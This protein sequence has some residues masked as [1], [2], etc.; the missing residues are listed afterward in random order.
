MATFVSIFT[1]RD[2]QWLKVP[3]I[4]ALDGFGDWFI[5]SDA[6]A[7]P[8]EEASSATSTS[9]SSPSSSAFSSQFSLSSSTLVTLCRTR[10][11]S[12][13]SLLWKT[14]SDLQA[15]LLK[16]KISAISRLAQFEGRDLRCGSEYEQC[17]QTVHK[18]TLEE[19]AVTRSIVT[20]T[21][22][23]KWTTKETIQCKMGWN[24]INGCRYYLCRVPISRHFPSSSSPSASSGVLTQPAPSNRLEIIRGQSTR[25]SSSFSSS[26]TSLLSTASQ[27]PDNVDMLWLAMRRQ[28]FFSDVVRSQEQPTGGRSSASASCRSHIF[29]SRLQG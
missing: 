24:L 18:L 6:L 14:L 19:A 20:A 21:P 7:K 13:T 9:V 4:P 27:P 3:T 17:M 22:E 15:T 12:Q 8:I 26:Y 23:I 28:V 1:L 5:A 2:G 10:S 16:D 11:H 29:V 25:L